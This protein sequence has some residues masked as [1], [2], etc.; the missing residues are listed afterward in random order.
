MI[1]DIFCEIKGIITVT[2]EPNT[3]CLDWKRADFDFCLAEWHRG[4]INFIHTKHKLLKK[5]KEKKIL[6]WN[7][8]SVFSMRCSGGV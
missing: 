5:R 8:N 6:E 2:R 1:I 7:L 3:V 4:H